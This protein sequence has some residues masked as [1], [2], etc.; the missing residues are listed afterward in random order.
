MEGWTPTSVKDSSDCGRQ[1]L[2]LG[3]YRRESS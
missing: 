2:V 1:M 3:K